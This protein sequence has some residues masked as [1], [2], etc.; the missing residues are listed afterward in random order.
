MGENLIRPPQQ[1]HDLVNFNMQSYL[2][3]GVFF[4][5]FE[6]GLHPNENEKTNK[7][8]QLLWDPVKKI[9]LMFQVEFF[10]SVVHM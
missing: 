1:Y 7:E 3:R 10:I 9:S 5:D 6:N 4:F 2:K 8:N